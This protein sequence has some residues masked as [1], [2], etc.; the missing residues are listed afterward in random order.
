MPRQLSAR[1]SRQLWLIAGA[2]A[3]LLFTVVYLVEGITRPGY[4]AWRQPVSDLSVGPG[5]EVQVVS[6]II[7][8]LLFIGFASELKR[9]SRWAAILVAIAGVGLVIAG[10]FVTDPIRGYPPGSTDRASTAHGIVHLIASFLVFTALPIACFVLS[11]RFARSKRPGWA[12]YSAASGLLMWIALAA[13]G[14]TNGHGGPAGV[15]ERL[16]IGSGWLWIAL[17]A[18]RLLMDERR[19]ADHGLAH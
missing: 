1:T 3:A 2:L 9:A 10:V 7:C 5:G 15:F 19:K 8:G 11:R 13:F 12:M 16:A 6:F 14:V 4:S 18:V 17:V